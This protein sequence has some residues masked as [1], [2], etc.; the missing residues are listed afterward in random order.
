MEKAEYKTR[1]GVAYKYWHS[2]LL[3]NRTL[4]GTL[5][6]TATGGTTWR[7][8]RVAASL[9]ICQPPDCEPMEEEGNSNA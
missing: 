4:M 2:Y 6:E 8:G 7:A 9:G 3:Q 1:A 5:M